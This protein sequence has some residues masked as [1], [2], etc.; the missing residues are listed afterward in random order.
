MPDV[1]VLVIGLADVAPNFYP[2]L[3]SFWRLDLPCRA[4][5]AVGADAEPFMLR[6]V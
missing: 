1:H 2:A 6:S 3:S 5:W 4:C